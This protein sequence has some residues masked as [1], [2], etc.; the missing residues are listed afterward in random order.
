[1][2]GNRDNFTSLSSIEGGTVTFGDN[3]KG[4]ILGIGSIGKTLSPE[5][6]DV[7]LVDGLRAT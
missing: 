4:K 2:T 6:N 7:L 1:M 5:L 3:G